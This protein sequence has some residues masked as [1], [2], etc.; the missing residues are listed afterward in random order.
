MILCLFVVFEY[1]GFMCKFDDGQYVIGYELLWFVVLYQCLFCVGLVVE[2]LF[3]ML[4]CEF[5]EMVLFYVCQGDVCFV[6]YCVEFVWVVCVLICVGEEF[7]VGQGVLGKVLLVFIDMQ[8]VCWYD[9]CE[10]LWVVLYGECDL[11]MV[12]VFVFVFN[13]V[14]ECVGVLMV[15]GLKLWFVVV[16]VMMVVFV[17]LLLFV[18]KVIVVFG[19]VGVCYDVFVVCDSFVWFVLLV[20]DMVCLQGV[21]CVLVGDVV[22]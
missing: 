4:S 17:M 15:L 8:D 9:V 19:G 7:L 10:Q 20:D 11:E 3:E 14:G 13:V 2:L 16:L 1:G 6:F 18:Q 22:V 21:G 12:L 5:G